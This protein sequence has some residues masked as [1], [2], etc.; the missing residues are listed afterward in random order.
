MEREITLG[1]IKLFVIVWEGRMIYTLLVG[2]H[3]SDHMV[4]HRLN[5]NTV[6]I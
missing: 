6:Y 1:L 2:R 5:I 3:C 4:Q